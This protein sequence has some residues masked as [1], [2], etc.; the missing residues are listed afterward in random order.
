MSLR[1]LVIIAGLLLSAGCG[2]SSSQLQLPADDAPAGT[3]I[4]L[5][6]SA[7]I[8]DADGTRLLAL[9]D[10]VTG[11]AT[12]ET[13]AD[14]WVQ[15][16][17]FHNDV[18]WGLGPKRKRQVKSSLAWHAPKGSADAILGDKVGPDRTV[19]AGRQAER[20]AA[21]TRATAMA[22]TGEAAGAPKG[23]LATA[24]QPAPAPEPESIRGGTASDGLPAS[25]FQNVRGA[26][27][28]APATSAAVMAPAS[29][30]PASL[31]GASKVGSKR[32]RATTKTD[33]TPPVPP[34]D[35]GPSA[36]KAFRK[37]NLRAD[38]AVPAPAKTGTA[39][40][41]ARKNE[42]DKDE[43]RS[44]EGE[45]EATVEAAGTDDAPASNGIK[46]LPPRAESIST[47]TVRPLSGSLQQS[48]S[49]D[50][51]IRVEQRLRKT[52]KCQFTPRQVT[53]RIARSARDKV[54]IKS[55]TAGIPALKTCLQRAFDKVHIKDLQLP[56]KTEIELVLTWSAGTS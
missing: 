54:E 53:V 14:S 18:S 19:A 46:K 8:T 3:V 33:E 37:F 7:H 41:P 51:R 56:P 48:A 28:R 1:M 35:T 11:A 16:R 32:A 17:L 2:S 50:L 24:E 15:V 38:R 26:I 31:P 44:D 40:S 21:D 43:N 13:S 4:E 52:D 47:V 5:S 30:R 49:R 9:N 36:P 34:T 6:G 27:E 39:E 29:P 20:S 25:E 22:N 42:S 55:S 12:I 45:T 23:V 10:Q